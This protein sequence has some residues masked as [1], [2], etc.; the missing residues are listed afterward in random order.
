MLAAEY[1]LGTLMGRARIRFETYLQSDPGLQLLVNKWSI[2]LA[3]MGLKLTPVKPSKRVWKSI[4]HRL[5]LKPQTGIW[6]N[7]NLLRGFTAVMTSV[8][9][10]MALYIGTKPPVSNQTVYIAV[11]QNQQSQGAWLISAQLDKDQ[12]QVKNITPQK[13]ANNKDFELWLIPS[14][15]QPPISMGLISANQNTNLTIDAEMH[16]ALRN[17][18]AMAVSLEPLGGSTTGAPTGPVLYQG[19][20]TIL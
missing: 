6:N 12:L 16:D 20:I 10:I 1:V 3:P 19:G 11:V 17:A 4:E 18:S 15:K 7:L 9:L 8:V 5:S 14:N 2:K 13:L